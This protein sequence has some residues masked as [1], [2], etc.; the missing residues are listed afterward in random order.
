MSEND[1]LTNPE[2]FSWIKQAISGKKELPSL[3]RKKTEPFHTRFENTMRN[4]FFDFDKYRPKCS[5][6]I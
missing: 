2:L 6:E 3:K 1:F 4:P 5:K